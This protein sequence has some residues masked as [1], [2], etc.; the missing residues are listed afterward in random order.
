MTRGALRCGSVLLTIFT[1]ALLLCG[2]AFAL[3]T[4]NGG[5]QWQN[6]LPQ[7]GAYSGGYFRDATHGWL[8]SGG[9]IFHTSDGGL[10]LTMQTRHNVTFRAITFANSSHGWA[11]GD[12]ASGKHGTA[13]IYR[14]TNGGLRWTR[15]RLD[16][17]G[18]LGAV[19]FDNTKD[20]WATSR[21]AVWH[22]TDGGLRWTAH[23]MSKH[24]ILH[25]VQA[26]NTRRVWVAGAGDTVLRSVDGGATWQR[27]H[28]GL[29]KNL[30]QVHF[31]GRSSGWVTGEGKIVH[32]TDGG[33]H[34]TVQLAVSHT[35]IGALS[36]ADAT[37]GWA[38]A[39]A[40]YHTTDGGA[41]WTQQT[42][43]PPGPWAWVVAPAASD[44]VVGYFDYLSHTTDGGAD[45]Q[46]T[47]RVAAD[48]TGPLDALQFTDASSGWAAGQAG[49]IL[50]TTDGGA[51]W[52]AQA[53]GTTQDLHDLTFVDGSDGWAVGGSNDWLNSESSSV[54]LHTSDGGATWAEQTNGIA[55]L[56]YDLAGV[57]FVGAD[58]G[59][60]VGWRDW[61]DLGGG[62]VV[63]TTDGGA[64]WAQQSLPAVD[65]NLL[66]GISLN[67]VAFAPDGLHGWAVGEIMGDA[68]TNSSVIVGTTDGGTTWVQQLDYFPP[69]DGNTSGASLNSIACID[70][71]HAVAVGFGNGFTE[72]FRTANGGTTWTRV[73]E[74]AAWGLELSD[75]VF[76]DATHGWAVGSTYTGTMSIIATTDGGAMWARQDAGTGGL[77]AVSFVSRTH[78]WVAGGESEILTTTTGGNAP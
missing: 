63:H 41:V 72:I 11:V 23:V 48:M 62:V 15:V 32:T 35:Q 52:L 65:P 30:S 53:S 34:W 43:S 75:V 24:D 59:W 31:A 12:P 77:S 74:P 2:S 45:W 66:S 49:E 37:H 29:A 6:P 76:A 60:A 8:L 54:V 39:G 13:I 4:G 14:T 1:A 5:W 68:G 38:T 27:L 18:G 19:S 40:V 47:T 3:S 73:A 26:R 28:T 71:R 57:T 78:G 36:F 64:T 44:A 42:T 7:G 50:N 22:T 61:G 55:G 70:A 51:D 46:P 33:A 25:G 10:T 56:P 16:F 9:T 21:E 69:N 20:G 17:H 67:D 58:D